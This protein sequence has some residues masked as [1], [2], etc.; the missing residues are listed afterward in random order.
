MQLGASCFGHGN[1]SLKVHV[2]GYIAAGPGF[3]GILRV[4]SPEWDV[5]L[6]ILHSRKLFASSLR[7]VG[8]RGISANL[9]FGVPS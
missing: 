4:Q 9:A 6:A 8:A 3:E 7:F 1:D 2:P 5:K